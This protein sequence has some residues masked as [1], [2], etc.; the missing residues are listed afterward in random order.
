MAQKQ[1]QRQSSPQPD[2]GVGEGAGS[3]HSHPANEFWRFDRVS[4][5]DRE[6]CRLVTNVVPQLTR[7]H[8][9]GADVCERAYREIWHAALR[10]PPLEDGERLRKEGWPGK[11]VIH[12]DS[13]DA[14]SH[15]L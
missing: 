4:G 11:R 1:Q 6:L 13:G 8:G 3:G 2:P 15:W 12:F 5:H 7:F 14:W 9:A 10:L